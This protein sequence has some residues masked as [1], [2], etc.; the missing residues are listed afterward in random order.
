[1]KPG[2]QDT[3]TY[4]NIYEAS[5]ITLIKRLF[6]NRISWKLLLEILKNLTQEIKLF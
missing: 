2:N 3:N 1:M 6:N 4:A 5:I